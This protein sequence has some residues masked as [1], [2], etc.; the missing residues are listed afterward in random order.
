MN[1]YG[2]GHGFSN[3]IS[4]GHVAGLEGL[5]LDHLDHASFGI[6]WKWNGF[7]RAVE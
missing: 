2:H 4:E 6:G 7:G 1:L 3:E 5:F